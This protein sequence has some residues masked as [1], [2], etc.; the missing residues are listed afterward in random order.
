M[1]DSTEHRYKPQSLQLWAVALQVGCEF[2]AIIRN[3]V[4][5]MYSPASQLVSKI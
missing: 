3:V 2:T 5:S 1:L 4:V